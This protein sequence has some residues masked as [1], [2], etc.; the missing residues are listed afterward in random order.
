MRKTT[1]L[2][3]KEPHEEDNLADG[4]GGTYLFAP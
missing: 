4:E 2:K 3:E 1:S